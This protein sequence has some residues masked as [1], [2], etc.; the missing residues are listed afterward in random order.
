MATAVQRITLSPS[1]DIPFNKLVLSQSNVRRVKAGVLELR[2]GI[3]GPHQRRPIAENN[4]D[5]LASSGHD[6]LLLLRCEV[7]ARAGSIIEG[8]PPQHA[9]TERQ[10]VDR[11]VLRHRGHVILH[12]IGLVSAEYQGALARPHVVGGWAQ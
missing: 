6:Y 8:Q 4:L 2:V 5:Q 7:G 12:R 3:A 1:R 11:E 10:A 9:E